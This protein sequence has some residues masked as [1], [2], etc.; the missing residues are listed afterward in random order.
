[1]RG[2]GKLNSHQGCALLFTGPG[3]LS[4]PPT[5]KPPGD[6]GVCKDTGPSLSLR[7]RLQLWWMACVLA[8]YVGERRTG[9]RVAAGTVCWC[10]QMVTTIGGQGSWSVLP[11]PGPRESPGDGGTHQQGSCQGQ[12]LS[13]WERVHLCPSAPGQ[14]SLLGWGWGCLSLIALL[15]KSHVLMN[16]AVGTEATLRTPIAAQCSPGG[17]RDLQREHSSQMWPLPG[18]VLPPHAGSREGWDTHAPHRV[19]GHWPH[20][21][22]EGTR[23]RDSQWADPD[24]S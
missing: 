7:C 14:G 13:R 19:P 18:N 9:E 24:S 8:R 1:M 21:T 15:E 2:G 6:W 12:E 3:T 23:G 11:V 17:Y 22:Q 10:S 16:V 5:A 4:P 20:P